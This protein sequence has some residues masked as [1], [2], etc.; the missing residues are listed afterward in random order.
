M[1]TP[2]AR[3]ETVVCEGPLMKRGGNVKT[4]KNRWFV[5]DARGL[6][7]YYK[8]NPPSRTLLDVIDL[9]EVTNIRESKLEEWAAKS[10]IPPQSVDPMMARCIELETPK[11][12]Y[13]LVAKGDD[14]PWLEQLMRVRKHARQ[15]R[16]TTIDGSEAHSAGKDL[17]DAA[18]HFGWITK[19][20]GRIR[21]WRRRF[22][23]LTAQ[24]MLLYAKDQSSLDQPLGSLHVR[25]IQEIKPP[26]ECA[27]ASS[28]SRP[29][30][31]QPDACFEIVTAKRKFWLVC[32]TPQEAQ[33]WV[34]QLEGA[35]LFYSLA[36]SS[37]PQAGEDGDDAD[38]R[39]SVISVSPS[40]SRARTP[41]TA[42][43]TSA[44]TSDEGG[45]AQDGLTDE[46]QH[47]V[48]DEFKQHEEAGVLLRAKKS[49][50]RQA[51]RLAMRES[52][53][54]STATTAAHRRIL[55]LYNPVSG[56]GQGRIIAE[57]HVGPILRLAKI[58]FDI[59]PTEYAG[60]A[61][62]FVSNL[63]L[64]SLDGLAVCGGDGLVS[65][66]MTGLMNRADE[67]AKT[68][69]IGIVPVGTANA[70]AHALD[71]NVAPSE[72]D[73]ISRAAL[74]IAKGAT[75]RVDVLD[76]HMQRKPSMVTHLSKSTVKPPS[77]GNSNDNQDGGGDDD[78]D[79]D[80]SS[81]DIDVV[82]LAA[83][84]VVLSRGSN[85]NNDSGSNSTAAPEDDMYGSPSHPATNEHIYGLSCIGWGLTGACTARA[86][87]LRW[88]PGQKK[89]RYDVAG[90]LTLL[91]DWPIV[92]KCKFEWLD[93]KT[94]EWIAEDI[95]IVNMIA[96]NMDKL[97]VAHA[98]CRGIK[99]DDGMIGLTLIDDTH[100]RTGTVAAAMSLK[101]G[102]YLGDHKNVRTVITSEFRMTPAEG[103]KAERIPFNIDGDPV[104]PA[105]VHVKVL[106][107]RMSVFAHPA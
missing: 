106:P 51:A 74:A 72:N 49:T 43:T 87:H 45:S 59:I 77:V 80:D 102:K 63:D 11:R 67:R 71:N 98:I 48:D 91:K 61:T 105:A 90:F 78:G 12:T 52:R 7:Q 94:N 62:H 60:H 95:G 38:E 100:S 96:A 39:M 29:K 85:A 33:T 107:Q 22:F 97:G 58:D 17:L 40:P 10:V 89:I 92:C 28:S 88:M 8:G 103:S 31:A 69:P 4:W 21:N 3:F 84:G 13:Y 57:H 6:L 76:I 47:M 24:G 20:G 42:T 75:R 83:D 79:D 82:T 54:S 93:S 99:P 50:L 34:N 1:S 35:C 26:E 66:V 56:A 23:I 2:S 27:W 53:L 70:M 9:T 25:H 37:M 101:K 14:I 15:Q 30:S 36:F 19:M 104:D 55:V 73:L 86:Q 68:F 16:R 5:L 18:L 41:S 64:E 65:E 81:D 32:D 44:T 46:I